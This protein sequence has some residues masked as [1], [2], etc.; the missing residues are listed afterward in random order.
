[1]SA[2][3]IGSLFSGYGGLD[4]GVQEVLGPARLAWVSDIE[5]GPVSLLAH[6]HPGVP[7]I[8]DI[9]RVDWRRARGRDLRRKPLPGSVS[10]RPECGNDARHPVRLV[11][12]DVPRDSDHPPAPRRVG[13]R[14]RS[15]QCLSL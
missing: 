7:N 6:H 10:G 1:M 14:T 2:Y 5:P 12:V 13:K 11:G 9:T 15:T 8:E 3:T 4:M